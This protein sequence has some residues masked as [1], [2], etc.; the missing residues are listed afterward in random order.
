VYIDRYGAYSGVVCNPPPFGCGKTID[1]GYNC[2]DCESDLCVD[3][4][5]K[6]QQMLTT[7]RGYHTKA[8]EI[9]KK[10]QEHFNNKP[11]FCMGD[12]I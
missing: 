11:G 12:M 6:A 3:C 7:F 1:E 2:P 9:N 4:Y 8:L 10:I 5:V